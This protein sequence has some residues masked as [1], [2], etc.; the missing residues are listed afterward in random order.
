MNKAELIDVL[1][2]KLGS[3]RR[4]AT[5]AVEH[6]VDTIVRTV[7]KGESVT[8]TGFGV[9]EQRRRAARVARNPR[10]GETVKVKPTS[11]PTFRP[12]AQFKAV[13]SGA[14]KL[15][16]DGP[17]V[18]RGSTAAPAKRA[19]A[20]KAAPAKKAPAKKAPAKKAPVKKAVVKKAAPAKKAPVK[21]AVVKK[22]APVKKAVTKA[23]AK[24]AATKAPAKK[25]ATKAPAKKAPAKKAPA[26]KGRK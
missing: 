12:G 11:V 8:I 16:A 3:D 9:F 4:Q 17:A 19:A 7:H 20:K 23:P 10:T 24:K 18:K 25:A 6:V 22:A 26:K 1:T 2:Q 13:V 15:P 14:Q 5:A 21:K